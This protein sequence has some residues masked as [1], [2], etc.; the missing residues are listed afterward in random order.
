MHSKLTQLSVFLGSG[1]VITLISIMFGLIGWFLNETHMN[2]MVA[3]PLS[4]FPISLEHCKHGGHVNFRHE[5]T[6][7]IQCTVKLPDGGQ[8]GRE[9]EFHPLTSGLTQIGFFHN[10]PNIN[11][12]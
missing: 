3:T 5:T 12:R 2:I 4:Y 8:M 1:I 10:L 7:R 6:C 11:L 9:S